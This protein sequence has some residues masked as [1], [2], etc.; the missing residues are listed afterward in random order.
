MTDDLRLDWFDW[1]QITVGA[2]VF[3]SV[4]WI[5]WSARPMP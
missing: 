3:L 2:L 4:V 1:F 5:C